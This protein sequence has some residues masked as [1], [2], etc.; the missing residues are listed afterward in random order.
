M[1]VE[2]VRA[3]NEGLKLQLSELQIQMKKM[4]K[5]EKMEEP[6]LYCFRCGVI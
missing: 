6:V 4:V 1:E 5:W 2:N 3:T